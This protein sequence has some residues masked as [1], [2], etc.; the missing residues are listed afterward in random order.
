[1]VLNPDGS[2]RSTA[3]LHTKWDFFR[4]SAEWDLAHEVAGQPPD[5]AAE[6]WHDYWQW[7]FKNIRKCANDPDAQIEYITRRRAELGLPPVE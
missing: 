5:A 3:A 6:T 2:V 1:M 4:S 7:R